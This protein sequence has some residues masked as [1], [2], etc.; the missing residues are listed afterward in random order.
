MLQLV[1]QILDF[2]KI[3]NGK[4]ILHVSQLDLNS[5][6][7]SFHKEFSVLSEENE[8]SFTFHLSDEEI[9]IWGDKEKLEIVIR[10]L[11][12]NAFKFTQPGGSI[13]VTTNLSEDGEHCFIRVEDTGVGIPQNKV[14]EV[15]ER[16]FQG[17]NY[18]NA[19]YP[20][21]GIG[22]ALSKQI[23][24]LHHGTID[25]ESKPT[26]GSI[27]VV[28][29]IL[30]KDHFNP[31]EVNFYVGDTVTELEGNVVED[32]ESTETEELEEDEKKITLPTVLVVEDNKD[33]CNLLRLQL[34]DKYKVYTAGNGLEGLKR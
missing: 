26:Q 34:D 31:S 32:V 15:F 10:N 1:N 19:Q 24:N 29:L 2:R 14:S 7:D 27:F 5:L 20:G 11:L 33:L 28:E 12:S 18:K 30:N 17:E 23:V 13:F 8:I 22:L 9:L 16:F 4:M 6:I 25:V 21:T 3:Q